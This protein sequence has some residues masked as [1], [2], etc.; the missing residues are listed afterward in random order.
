MDL[1]FTPEEIAFRDEVRAL[2]RRKTC[3]PRSRQNGRGPTASAKRTWSLAAHPERQGLGGAAL[4]GGMGRHRLDA[5]AA[6]YLFSDEMQQAPAPGAARLRRQHGRAGDR[7]LRQRGAEAAI[8]A[9]H[10]QSRRLVVPGLFRARRRLRPRLAADPGRARRRHTTSSTARRPGPRWR[11]TP[12]GFSACAAPIRRRKKQE[13]ISFI[14]IDMKTP[15]ITV[16]PIQT[17]DGGHEVNEVF[18]DDV[19]CRPKIWS[20]RRTRAGTTP[21]SCSATSAPASPASASPRRASAASRNWPRS[22]MPA[23]SR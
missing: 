16:R 13:G 15:G 9:A 10:R 11:S 4:A 23:A 12:T 7:H 22:S 21:S 14:L 20:A 18:F 6:L 17:I 2:L 3:R 1:R 8:P 19:G 5:G